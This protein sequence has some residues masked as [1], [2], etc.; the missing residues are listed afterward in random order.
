M[1]NIAAAS[2]AREGKIAKKWIELER[3][4][5]TTLAEIRFRKSANHVEGMSVFRKMQHDSAGTLD[6]SK[7]APPPPERTSAAL[8]SLDSFFLFLGLDSIQK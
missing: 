3:N 5:F 7:N 2:I 1:S 6:R 8:Y 4:L